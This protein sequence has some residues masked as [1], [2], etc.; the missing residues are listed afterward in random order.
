MPCERF[1]GLITAAVAERPDV[2]VAAFVP[3]FPFLLRNLE[4]HRRRGEAFAVL[5]PCA[6]T[7]TVATTYPRMHV[8]GLL[9]Y[10]SA[11]RWPNARRLG[12]ADDAVVAGYVRA[13]RLTVVAPVPTLCD[14]RDE[15][16]SLSKPS[17]RAGPGRRAALLISD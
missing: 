11:E 16:P 14:H 9:A 10:T 4:A 13:N 12:T 3:G 5:P 7:P 15:V 8:E 17:H 6:F 2:I 1:A